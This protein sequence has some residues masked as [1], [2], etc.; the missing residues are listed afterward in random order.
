LGFVQHQWALVRA[1]YAEL[2]GF[3]PLLTA[4]RDESDPD[5]LRALISP[6]EYLVDE[7]AGAAGVETRARLRAVIESTFAPAL[8]SLGWPRDAERKQQESNDVRLR[9]AELL[10]LVAVIA[11]SQV[12]SR[13]AEAQCARYLD[14]RTGLDPNLVAAVLSVGA[15]N[16][17][18]ARLQVLLERSEY[19]PTPQ[20]RRR[21]RMALADVRDPALVQQVLEACLTPSIP[22]QDVAFVMSRLLRNADGREL[23][24]EF[25]QTRWSELRERIPAM[26]VA[27][28]IEA[29]PALASETHRR[30][31]KQFFATHPLPTATRALRQADE[32]FRLNAAFRKRALPQLKDWLRTSST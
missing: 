3:L 14:T 19:D 4:L 12:A 9:R 22:T 6:C 30:A 23:A 5:V 11:E 8:A 25:M 32:R 31:L 1:G 21:Y 10:H 20:A 26:L 24:F 2:G 28:L 27:R 18:D 16:A 15:R 7:L 17:D 29:T 13:E